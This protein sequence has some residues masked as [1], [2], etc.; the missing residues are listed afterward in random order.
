MRTLRP[1]LLSFVALSSV[2]GAGCF[3]VDDAPLDRLSIYDDAGFDSGSS[4]QVAE[5]CGG[6]AYTVNTSQTFTLDTTGHANDIN[7]LCA[8]SAGPDIFLKVDVQAGQ[9]W[10]FHLFPTGADKNNHD[11]VLHVRQISGTTCNAEACSGSGGSSRNVCGLGGDEHFGVRFTTSGTYAVAV[12]EVDGASTG[13]QYSLAVFQPICGNN[14]SEH[15]EG[16]EDGNTMDNDGCDSFCRVELMSGVS[17]TEPNEDRFWANHVLANSAGDSVSITGSFA[18]STCD[19]DAFAVALDA[20]KHL[21]VRLYENVTGSACYKVSPGTP[22]MPI[23]MRV[24]TPSGAVASGGAT[25]L[26]DGMGCAYLDATVGATSG[27]LLVTLDRITGQSP[28]FPY[29]LQLDIN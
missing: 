10:H 21:Q 1:G 18:G 2:L 25:V 8:P 16:C 28:D 19:V 4:V 17:E 5:A 7:P 22:T 9:Y 29:R 23:Q 12:D 3:I 13:T 24:T 26:T 11:P 20:N 15:G 6:A 14:I 27:E